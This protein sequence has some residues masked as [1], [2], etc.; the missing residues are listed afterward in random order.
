M[1]QAK[2]R[3]EA[4]KNSSEY[5][6]YLQDKDTL[7]SLVGSLAETSLKDR[8]EFFESL[9]TK[10]VRKRISDFEAAGGFAAFLADSTLVEA[11]DRS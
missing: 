4:F 11:W 3:I 5:Q 8:I 9:E 6:A 2:A 1:A 7:S 10:T